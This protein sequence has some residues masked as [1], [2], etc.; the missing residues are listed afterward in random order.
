ML[1]ATSR[2]RALAADG[3]RVL[4]G[5]AAQGLMDARIDVRHRTDPCGRARANLQ[6]R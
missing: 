2:S 5:P 4:L 6:A 3:Y 1:A